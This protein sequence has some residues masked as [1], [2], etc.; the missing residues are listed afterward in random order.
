MTSPNACS[1]TARQA[2]R[3]LGLHS[4]MVR[5]CSERCMN[6]R[7][8]MCVAGSMNG[9]THTPAEIKELEDTGVFMRRY[10]KFIENPTNSGPCT[11]PHLSSPPLLSLASFVDAAITSN[12]QA[13]EERWLSRD[14][15]REQLLETNKTCTTITA[16]LPLIRY[17]CDVRCSPHCPHDAAVTLCWQEP[18]DP[19]AQE[20]GVEA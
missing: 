18:P 3:K 15:S 7:D 14:G 6:A 1:R 9:R 17:I 10:R 16:N 19:W 2:R 5:M 12:V 20:A 8:D 13:W 4:V 11:S